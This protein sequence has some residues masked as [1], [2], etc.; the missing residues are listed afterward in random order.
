[1]VTNLNNSG[2][3][4]LRYNIDCAQNGDTI[5]FQASLAGD[6]IFLSEIITISKDLVILSEVNPRIYVMSETAGEFVISAGHEVEFI[7]LNFI[8]GESGMPGAFDVMG[9]LILDDCEVFRN[10]ELS[11]GT[12]LVLNNGGTVTIRGLCEIHD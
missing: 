11:P 10:P 9:D 5:R 12:V 6:T 8:S 1:M 3:G 7:N 4:S 2:I